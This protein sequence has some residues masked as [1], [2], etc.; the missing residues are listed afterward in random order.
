MLTDTRTDI[1]RAAA[2]LFKDKGYAGTSIQDIAAELGLR[3]SSLYH[4]FTSKEEILVAILNRG[5]DRALEQLAALRDQP[6]TAPERLERM[7]RVHMDWISADFDSAIAVMILQRGTALAD[8]QRARF[9]EKRRRY[10]GLLEQLLRQ[11]VE[12]GEIVDAD[13]G[14]TALA[15]LGML[16]WAVYWYRRGGRRS[17]DEIAHHFVNLIV[18]GL[19]PRQ[20]K[21]SEF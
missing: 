13:P 5:A 12:R 19:R 21:S 4:H 6:G 7:A 2:R 1:L 18:E 20:E 14:L 3:K 8:D 17:G 16:N 11:G 15:L 10:Q 9:L